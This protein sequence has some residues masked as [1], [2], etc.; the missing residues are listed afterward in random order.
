MVEEVVS[1]TRRSMQAALAG[2]SIGLPIGSPNRR[3]FDPMGWRDVAARTFPKIH[4]WQTA[5]EDEQQN[6]GSH[7]AP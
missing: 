2:A 7:L 4:Q 3:P 1:T 6:D 5:G